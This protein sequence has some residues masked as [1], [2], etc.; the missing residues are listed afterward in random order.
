MNAVQGLKEKTTLETACAVLGMPRATYY[1]FQNRVFS[2]ESKKK[3]NSP[4]SLSF[5]ERKTV[6]EVLNSERFVDY[7]P[8]EVYAILLDEGQY[9]CSKR[10][11]YRILSESK[12]LTR[13][14]EIRR[15]KH[16]YEKPELL[17][18]G[19]NEVCSW[20]ITKLKGPMKWNHFHLYVIMDIYSRCVVGW[21]VAHQESATLAK[22]LI[23][24]SC[25]RQGIQANQLTL[26]A[27]RGS[28]MKSKNLFKVFNN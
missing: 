3:K 17:A 18:T 11:M 6:L 22:S 25:H 4:L 5:D 28:S 21:M 15:D 12:Q 24:E 10:S 8:S 20:D 9:Y 19:P 23:K 7:S 16:K 27:D 26:H 13:R 1:R 14:R 2:T